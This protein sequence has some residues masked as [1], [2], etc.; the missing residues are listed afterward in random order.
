MKKEVFNNELEKY[1]NKNIRIS[2][3]RMLELLPD[4]FYHIPASSSG[5]NHPACDQGE[6]GLVRHTK[7]ALAFLESMFDNPTF[8]NYDSKKKDLIRFALLI[9]DGLK[10]GLPQEEHTRMDHPVLMANFLLDNK[11]TL[12]I[13]DADI[14]F[15]SDLVISHMGPWNR[16]REGKVIMPVPVTEEQK[17]VHLCDYVASRKFVDAKFE[18]YEIVDSNRSLSLNN[19]KRSKK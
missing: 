2:A 13:S 10:S 14:K 1:E 9:H 8:C 12:L 15:V 3:E 17:L 11:N 4:Y 7:L 6:G 5:K 19:K 18:G 16:D